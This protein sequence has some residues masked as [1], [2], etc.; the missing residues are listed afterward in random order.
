MDLRGSPILHIAQSLFGQMRA[1]GILANHSQR[2]FEVLKSEI[3]RRV[4]FLRVLVGVLEHLDPEASRELIASGDPVIYNTVEWPPAAQP[5]GSF[6]RAGNIS[7][8][9]HLTSWY[10][11]WELQS[12]EH[13]QSAMVLK[14]VRA[15]LWLVN[16]QGGIDA[17]IQYIMDLQAKG[18]ILNR[19]VAIQAM[20]LLLR[21]RR[22]V[23]RD[24]D[25]AGFFFENVPTNA[26]EWARVQFKEG[27]FAAAAVR[28][29][30]IDDLSILLG[31]AEKEVDQVLK[32]KSYDSWLVGQLALHPVL[33]VVV[34]TIHEFEAQHE[35]QFVSKVTR[36]EEIRADAG[37]FGRL[38][39]MW[40]GK[41]VSFKYK[42]DFTM[43]EVVC[44]SLS[45]KVEDW[46]DRILDERA[47]IPDHLQQLVT[48]RGIATADL[49]N[50]WERISAMLV[51][52][53]GPMLFEDD[54][55]VLARTELFQP[56]QMQ[57]APSLAAFLRS[58]DAFENSEVKQA[59]IQLICKQFPAKETQPTLLDISSGGPVDVQLLEAVF[60]KFNKEHASLGSETVS[61][62]A[63]DLFRS[64]GKF[65]LDQA[66]VAL[67]DLYRSICTDEIGDMIDRGFEARESN[68][69]F[70]DRLCA[71]YPY[72]HP[73]QVERAVRL[74]MD[75]QT[76]AALECMLAAIIIEPQEA[77]R[78]HSLGV[79]LKK[80]GRKDDSMLAYGLA[81][82]IKNNAK[83]STATC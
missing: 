40:C 5:A 74:D 82:V 30:L 47:V 50:G 1:F 41:I 31:R 11:S 2:P 34:S 46:K 7:L 24:S 22:S 43:S 72:Y 32:A 70:F 63:A 78:W 42:S 8:E 56:D 58:I 27:D 33:S 48:E 20:I 29:D 14:V 12:D 38:F 36:L 21:A 62:E 52:I 53:A 10:L 35:L 25:L 6:E 44:S 64:A 55:Y 15:A 81:D 77:T 26:S 67:R 18:L 69:S 23:Q 71:L 59:I 73:A 3:L 65:D 4:G 17:A 13:P 9:Q 80:L 57:N 75:G 83:G 37:A 61:K 68:S 54:F 49:P 28:P 66:E 45:T 76:N 51:P 19:M 60:A 39:R 79:I 16:G